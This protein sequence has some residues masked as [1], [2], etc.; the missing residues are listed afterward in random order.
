MNKPFRDHLKQLYS[1]LLM[2]EDHAL[3]PCL[4]RLEKPSMILIC[5]WAIMAWQNNSSEATA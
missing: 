5:Q 3:N 2:G 1:E 4:I